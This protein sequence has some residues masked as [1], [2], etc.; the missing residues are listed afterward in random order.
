MKLKHYDALGYFCLVA[1]Q[2]IAVSMPS[3]S[4]IA[5]ESMMQVT[6]VSQLS[7]V[8]P[9]DWAFQALQSLVERYG[10]IAGYPDRTY[11][12]DRALTRYEFAAGLNA[13]LD[14][15]NELIAAATA[16]LVKKEDLATLQKLQEEFAAE[17]TTIRGRVDALESR[18]AQLEKQ[19][20][21]TTTKLTGESVIALTSV[22]S[23]DNLNGQRVDRNPTLSHRTRLNFD[24]SFTGR[25]LLRTRLQ[26]SNISAISSLTGTPEGELAFAPG[27]Q[28]QEESEIELTRLSYEFPLSEKTTVFLA[29][30]EG[31]AEE[32]AE[33]INPFF[34][35]DSSSGSVSKFGT[36]NP[37]YYLLEGSGVGITH[38][39]SDA[40]ELSVGYLAGDASEP[41]DKNGLFNG[42]YGAIAQLT[43]E[44]SEAIAFGLT[45][46]H[47][48]NTDYTTEGSAGSL[49]ANLFTA[50]GR[51]VVTNSFGLQASFR[52]SSAF[53]INGWVGYTGARVLRLGDGNIWNWAVTL[54][55]PDLGKQGNFAGFVIGMEPKLTQI[56]SSVT[57]VTGVSR[58]RDTSL[59]FEAFYQYRV[60][61]NLSITPGVIWLT[62]PNHDQRNQDLVIGTIR[63]TFTF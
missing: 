38:E 55:F 25:D 47:A 40:L 63:T 41:T 42:S 34:D 14:R 57:A 50:I 4:A 29:A 51:A 28:E 21:S 53:I 30:N 39:F 33:S 20:F 37:I 17:L 12:G 54:G 60:N 13:C 49:N 27:F 62:A 56:D 31:E 26:A 36:R 1:I 61:D 44:P 48:Y 58:D 11:R 10:C 23:G 3:E 15:V 35:G 24:T 43:F 22:F 19:Q 18:T 45:Y 9:T 7:D 6:S 32:F 52:P 46:I 2:A 59:H 8:R 5:S 16:D